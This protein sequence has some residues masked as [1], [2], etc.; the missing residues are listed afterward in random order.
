MEGNREIQ[1]ETTT[2]LTYCITQ[3]KSAP[4][5]NNY[6]TN[7]V[8]SKP[9]SYTYSLIAIRH[10]LRCGVKTKLKPLLYRYR[11]S[12]EQVCLIIPGQRE[13]SRWESLSFLT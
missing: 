10:R 8:E 1:E 4:N 6:S 9:F 11:V 13:Q 3:T 2:Y 12:R 7:A 5:Q